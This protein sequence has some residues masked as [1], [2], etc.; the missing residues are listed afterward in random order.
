ML[1]VTESM[2]AVMK[3]SFVHKFFEARVKIVED[4]TVT[5]KLSLKSNSKIEASSPIGFNLVLE[6][7]GTTGINR[8]EISAE[9]TFNGMVTAGPLYG[10]TIST[11]SFVV[12]P[13]RPEVRFDSSVQVDST[14]F[15]AKNT[16]AT[17]LTTD[18]FSV[19]STTNAFDDHLT[20][21]V[22]FSIR[23]S[24]LALKCDANAFALGMKIR[25]QVEA[26]AGAG[27]ILMRVETNSEHSENRVYSLFTT[28]FD[29]NGLVVTTDAMMKLI[30]NEATHKATLK[31]NQD[32]LTTSGTTTVQSPLALENSFSGGI[33]T[34]RA[35]LSVTNKAAT[36]GMKLDN[37]NNMLITLS[38][39]DF[40]SNM[41]AVAGSIA[42]YTHDITVAMKPYTATANVVNKF[43]VLMAKVDNE[44]MLKV[45]PYK[46]DL[47]GNVKAVVGDE[48]LKHTYQVNYADMTANA[49]CST[50]G[51]LF[52][53]HMS[54][55]T[56]V[57]VFGLAAKI[58]NDA[59][60]N[61]NP[62]RFDHTIRCSIVPFDFNLD[63]IFNA[64]G[65]MILFGKHSGQL[66]GKWLLRAQPL[67][68]TSTH[69]CRAS[70][71][72]QLND[73]Y[74][75][76][77][78][79]D[80][81]MDNVLSP[82][83]QKSN[84][85]MRFKV[86]D[87]DFNQAFSAYNTEERAGVEMSSSFFTSLFDVDTRERQEFTLSGLVKYDK[88]TDSRIIQFPFMENLPVMVESM[89]NIIV[90]FAETLQNII[91]NEDVR[92]KLEAFPQYVS[93]FMSQV[94]FETYLTKAKLFLTDITNFTPNFDI[95]MEDVEASIEGLHT[96]MKEMLRNLNNLIVTC[97]Q[98]VNNVIF[99]GTQP[100]IQ[101]LIEIN[102]ALNIKAT[103]LYVIET[104]R[105]G[106]QAID[107]RQLEG[108]RFV[109][110]RDFDISYIKRE[111]D[112][113]M[114]D[115]KRAVESF[116]IEDF[117]DDLKDFCKS[118]Y[119]SLVDVFVYRIPIHEFGKIKRF[120]LETIRERNIPEML[121]ATFA[122]MTELIGQFEIDKKIAY[123][124]ENVMAL[125]RQFRIEETIRTVVTMAKDVELPLMQIFQRALDYLKTTEMKDLIGDLNVFM[126]D[127][128]SE[129][130]AMDYNEFVDY[131]NQIVASYT[132]YVND[133]IRTLEIPQKL[134]ATREFVNFVLTSMQNV[135]ERIREIRVRDIFVTLKDMNE[136]LIRPNL[137]SFVEFIKQEI[138]DFDVR[139][140]IEGYL[141]FLSFSHRLVIDLIVDVLN[142]IVYYTEMMLP[143]QKITVEMRQMAA[144]FKAQFK[145]PE[146][147]IPSF[148]IPFTDI[149]V[150]SSTTKTRDVRIPA[151]FDIPE[152]TIMGVHTVQATTISAY[153][154][155]Q[156][157]IQ[158][159]DLFV[160]TEIQMFDPEVFFGELTMGFLPPMPDIT[161][162]DITFPEISV[163][164][165]P[166]IPVEK[167]VESL[168]IPDFRLPSVP[169]EVMVPCFGKLYGEIKLLTPIYTFKTSAEFQNSTESEMTPTFTAFLTSQG[170]SQKFEIL[171][172]KLESMSRIAVP[173][174]SRVVFSETV[175]YIHKALEVEH[176]GSISLYGLSA[177]GQTKTG[178]KVM[179]SFYTANLMNIA[180]IAIEE[181]MSSSLETTYTHLVNLPVRDIRHELTLT[182]KAVVRQDGLTLTLTADNSANSN[183]N[184]HNG[185]HKSNMQLSL[186]PRMSTIVFTGDTDFVLLKMKQQI[187]GELQIP[188]YIKFN[189]RN[190][191]EAPFIKN[192]LFVATGHAN[193]YDMQAEVKVNHDTE[194]F[195]V[196][197]GTVSNG[198]NFLV[199]PFE[200]VFEFQNKGNNKVVL[201]EILVAKID[202]QN[203]YSAILRPG[204]QQLNTVALARINQHRVFYNFTVD[205]NPTEAGVIVSMESE[206]DLGFLNT[207]I[208]IPEFDLPFVDFRSPAISDVN[209]YEQM[210]LMNIL[211][212]TEQ[213]VNMDAK[214]VYQKIRFVD[215][216]GMMQMPIMGNV[217]SELAFKS[218]IINLNVNAGLFAEDNLV[219]RLRAATASVFESL[220]AKLDGTTSLSTKTGV[221]LANSMSL[222]NV[223][224]EGTHDS[225]VSVIPETLEVTISVATVGKVALPVLTLEVNQNLLADTKTKAN[226]VSTFN[227]KGNL[228][229]PL[230]N[231]VGKA[232]GDYTLKM[233]GT[234]DDVSMESSFRTTMDGS[235]IEDYSVLGFLD[236]NLNLYINNNGLRSTGKFIA[237]GKLNN[238][239]TKILSM[240]VNEN[241]A[242]EVSLSR[243]YAMLKYSGMNEA[244]IFNFN[245]AGKQ[246]A[247][248]TVDLSMTSPMT[249][250]IEIDLSQPTSMG[251]FN[252]YVK[253]NAGVTAV[254]QKMSTILKFV[255]PFY[256]TN[257]AA[258][259]EGKAPVFKVSMTSSANSAF[260]VLNYDMIGKL[261]NINTK[262][263][264]PTEL[265]CELT[266]YFF[267]QLHPLR[268][269]KLEL[270]T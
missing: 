57:E 112:V 253:N 197:S 138:L 145:S 185:N 193:L 90:R 157:I 156:K 69:E 260:P 16:I 217:I 47:T 118:V 10:K 139:S 95:S 70:V 7:I 101:H 61:S 147:I 236:N 129:M 245:T 191:A 111:L 234:F 60:F 24:R 227:F 52:G 238:G 235:V 198:L 130:K 126:D 161:L 232:N 38:T 149:V 37:T 247:T 187:N 172:Y 206:S 153:A 246:V 166:Q 155:K 51:R 160:N 14:I 77:T 49:K 164:T 132:V 23:N 258:D 80:N 83:E 162:P 21:L 175:K 183:F 228:N 113:A 74:S 167:L 243:V 122:K 196:V 64:D 263:I 207:P 188:A 33:D 225:T 58:T 180:F 72:Q 104:I 102:E 233:E 169:T 94:D 174:M 96:F 140:D 124:M 208:T 12:I 262:N 81:K 170:T 137:L 87:F 192:S 213:T 56:E 123:L 252:V 121:S 82:Q 159:I 110:L 261:I 8:E 264:L 98:T 106:I 133:L 152:F 265:L 114:R 163:P 53:T 203:D 202:L 182:Q 199:R 251:D 18:A 15:Q 221:K 6:H 189:I 173:K 220:R 240:E 218:A 43:N 3:S 76:E 226:A 65:D 148:T 35:T 270:W 200:F 13:F 92:A 115:L 1:D 239:A 165:I 36:N 195:G 19:V 150:P 120:V 39:F 186:T 45:E 222:E 131:A 89:K 9:S 209:L 31:F 136:Q 59:R 210:G 34:S 249:V 267:T 216:M 50:T 255:S 97:G 190:E 241:R 73:G 67:A 107:L 257:V 75:I 91:N 105:E 42:S 266:E 63:A 142:N 71:T 41:E 29:A 214:V 116:D 27:A 269:L 224:I 62:V 143:N 127:L 28:S 11:Q 25:N 128:I 134:E 32:G 205:N 26:T 78:I 168:Q 204:S 237:D 2:N 229:V 223:H 5:D 184:G 231:T 259:V 44:A 40:N 211:T 230:I 248:A 141:R 135:I 158:C 99:S 219:M 100:L 22:D 48:E 54:H 108:T 212:T 194:L 201:T 256:T 79:F 17:S 244:N 88:N 215:I 55:N 30:E 250:D 4:A 93:E 151:Q 125:V 254:V 171:N 268:T 242:V 178:I 20:H 179:T 154:I 119:G 146:L 177:Q 103:I 84:L 117:V 109:F 68:F 86:N 176:Q 46:M 66:Y 85:R 181:G 144:T